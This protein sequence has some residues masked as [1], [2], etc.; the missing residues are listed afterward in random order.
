M[1]DTNYYNAK[2]NDKPLLKRKYSDYDVENFMRGSREVNWKIQGKMDGWSDHKA[3]TDE[4]NSGFIQK[5]LDEESRLSEG[6]RKSETS[7][8]WGLT[9]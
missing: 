8:V 5:L 7:D 4:R 6:W 1:A 9:I 2:I 3:Y